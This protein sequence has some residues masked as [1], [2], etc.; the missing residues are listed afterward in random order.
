MATPRPDIS[1]DD[2]RMVEQTFADA[3]DL[4]TILAA[5]DQLGVAMRDWPPDRQAAARQYVDT[6]LR[7]TGLASDQ[8]EL[9]VALEQQHGTSTTISTAPPGEGAAA[10]TSDG[11]RRSYRVVDVASFLAMDLPPREIILAPWLTAQSLSMV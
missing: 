9:A 10:S 6:L 8:A 11:E 7:A 4:G 3:D 2:R 5:R 1:A